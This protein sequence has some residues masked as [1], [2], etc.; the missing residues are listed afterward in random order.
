MAIHQLER[1]TNLLTVLLSA[2]R[3]VTFE[4]IRNE[5]R[6]QYPENLVAAR[7]ATRFSGY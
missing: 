3:H 2:R 4:E 7:A 1:V 6:G 5:L